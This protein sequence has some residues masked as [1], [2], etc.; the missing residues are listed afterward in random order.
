MGGMGER[1]NW[2]ESYG[3]EKV[4]MWDRRRKRRRGDKGRTRSAVNP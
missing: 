2:E 1:G 4:D 3:K